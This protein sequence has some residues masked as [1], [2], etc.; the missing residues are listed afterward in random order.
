[1]SERSLG[2]AAKRRLA[3][4]L[5]AGPFQ[6]APAERDRDRYG[7]KLRIV[8]R[9]G[10]SIGAVLVAEGLAEPWKGRRSS[11]CGA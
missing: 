3:V 6:L 5:G 10:K 7:R 1:V 9:G 2:H 4:L 8:T 11:W